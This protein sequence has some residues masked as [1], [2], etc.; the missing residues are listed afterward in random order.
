[1][2]ALWPVFPCEEKYRM[3]TSV[4]LY[5]RIRTAEGCYRYK[6]PVYASNHRLKPLCALVDGKE[7]RHP[8]GSYHL[9]YV[10]ND[11]RDW[12]PVGAEPAQALA[13]LSKRQK[14]QAAIAAGANFVEPE[15]PKPNAQ[16]PLASAVTEYLGT[17]R[18]TG[19]L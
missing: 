14:I 13:D 12:E 7:Q 6:K 1:M 5:I 4:S 15:K 10:R 18:S 3:S 11:K 2:K 9:R 17:S 19:P 16:R 8:E